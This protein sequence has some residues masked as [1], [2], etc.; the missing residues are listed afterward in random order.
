MQ[1]TW[2]WLDFLLLALKPLISSLQGPKIASFLIHFGL[3]TNGT[4]I[5]SCFQVQQLTSFFQVETCQGIADRTAAPLQEGIIDL[6]S[7]PLI[8]NPYLIFLI[9]FNFTQ[10][11]KYMCPL[12]VFAIQA[13]KKIFLKCRNQNSSFFYV[14]Q[15]TA[16]S[17]HCRCNVQ[18][19][20]SRYI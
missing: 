13:K 20:R 14:S 16:S 19:S 11:L 12:T 7:V 3:K 9:W 2:Y 17:Q 8:L 15:C 4:D 10:N 6:I 5:E 18:F 1:V